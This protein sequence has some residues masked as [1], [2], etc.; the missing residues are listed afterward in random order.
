MKKKLES[1][2]CLLQEMPKSSISPK[3]SYKKPSKQATYQP[4]LTQS[5]KHARSL[6]VY[7]DSASRSRPTSTT[8]PKPAELFCITCN[9]WGLTCPPDVKYT[10]QT[11]QE[12][13]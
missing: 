12:N 8:P 5:L 10:R 11:L 13:T 4:T 1:K 6:R 2:S 9:A 3:V 7:R